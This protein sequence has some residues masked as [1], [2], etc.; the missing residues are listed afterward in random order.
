MHLFEFPEA[1]LNVRYA[2]VKEKNA[3]KGFSEGLCSIRRRG[4]LL[5]VASVLL[6]RIHFGVPLGSAWRPASTQS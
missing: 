3:Q 6:G 4:M 1:A 5:L 2:A